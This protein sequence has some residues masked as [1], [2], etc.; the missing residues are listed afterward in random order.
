[1]S[2]DDFGALLRELAGH[3]EPVFE[4]VDGGIY[5]YLDAR[6]KVCN[7][8]LAQ[9]YGRTVAE[10]SAVEDFQEQFVADED[11][12]VYCDIYR[13]TIRHFAWPSPYRFSGL[14]KDG[15][16][17]E[18]EA[19]VV[20]LTFKGQT[21]AYHFVRELAP[22]ALAGS[23][24]ELVVRYNRAWNKHDVDAIVSMH[25]ADIVFENRSLGERVEGEQVGPHIAAIFESWPGLSLRF[26]NRHVSGDLIVQEWTLT[27]TYGATGER[28]EWDGVDLI[29]V[30][31]GLVA[32]KA[33]YSGSAAA[34]ARL[35]SP[36]S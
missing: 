34:H 8:Q 19:L 3:L 5:L 31:D 22:T 29:T 9:T 20:P 36:A 21:F 16:S 11:R 33:F 18:A 26:H 10:W 1:M 23:V 27:A 17:F 13:R 4:N 6:H 14:R 25:A 28:A 12:P 30:S 32:R 35:G 7:E 24:E 15:S 2:D